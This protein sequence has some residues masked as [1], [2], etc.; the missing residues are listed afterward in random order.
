MK[1]RT[2]DEL[3]SR[4]RCKSS[5]MCLSATKDVTDLN[6]SSS[7]LNSAAG[8]TEK[9]SKEH[10]NNH[11]RHSSVSDS[12]DILVILSLLVQNG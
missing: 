4:L 12:D 6:L 2:D 8:P 10:E 9:Y 11:R 7:K 5:R 3:D 1:S